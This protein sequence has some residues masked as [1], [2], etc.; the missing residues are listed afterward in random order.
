MGARIEAASETGLQLVQWCRSL[1]HDVTT[2]AN[3]A[4]LWAGLS[5]RILIESVRFVLVKRAEQQEEREGEIL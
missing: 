5:P 2:R 1:T 3:T 4:P